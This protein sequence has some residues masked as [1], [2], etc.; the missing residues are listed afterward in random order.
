MT[1]PLVNV[2]SYLLDRRL[3]A[4]D[5][6]R[7]ALTG[8]AG[9]VTYA[10]LHDRVCRTAGGLRRLGLQREKRILLLMSDSPDLVVL[11]LAAMRMGAVPVPVSTMLRA[12]GVAELLRDS[13]ARLL[14]VTPEL[15]DT[16]FTAAASAREL[17]AIVADGVP[18]GRAAEVTV[19]VHS[20]DGLGSGA[21]D[22]A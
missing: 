5:G 8:V 4:G 14:A 10:D 9:D 19:A 20:L 11:Y 1:T 13:R 16:A 22:D 3:D 12:D 18:A 21:A 2:S 17:T 6:A 15:V 7:T